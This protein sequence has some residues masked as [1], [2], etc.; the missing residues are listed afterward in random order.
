MPLKYVGD[1]LF[2]L[3]DVHGSDASFMKIECH[4]QLDHWKVEREEGARAGKRGFVPSQARV[5]SPIPRLSPSVQTESASA[6]I[7]RWG[8]SKERKGVGWG[9]VRNEEK[10]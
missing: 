3:K 6:L 8:G 9:I 2:S 4:V 7:L 1:K 5:F 10:K